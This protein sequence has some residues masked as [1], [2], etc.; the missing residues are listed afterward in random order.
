MKRIACSGIGLML[1]FGL[2][3][4][5]AG[6]QSQ[7]PASDSSTGSSLGDYARQV[8]KAPA[9]VAKPKVFDNDNLPGEGSHLSIIG[10]APEIC[11]APWLGNDNSDKPQGGQRQCS[12]GCWRCQGHPPTQR[13]GKAD[14][15]SRRQGELQKPEVKPGRSQNNSP[16][17][18]TKIRRTSR[19]PGNNGATRLRRKKIRS[20]C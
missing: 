19:L 5:Q 15:K 7:T 16:R 18:P 11:H 12:S 1:S 20:T 8:R 3:A 9:A 13:P 14:D 17:Q 4:V 2:L 10:Q 6:A